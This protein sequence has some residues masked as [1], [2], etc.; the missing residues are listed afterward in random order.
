MAITLGDINVTLQE[1][2][3]TLKEQAQTT[4]SLNSNISVLVK[5]MQSSKLDDREKEIERSNKEK[6]DKAEGKGRAA[7]GGTGSGLFAGLKKGLFAGLLGA[8]GLL[9][10]DNFDTIVNIF[11]NLGKLLQDIINSEAVQWAMTKLKEID[12]AGAFTSIFTT[13][14]DLATSFFEGVKK[15]TEGDY[16][17]AI[18]ENWDG[19]GAAVLALLAF[20]S[21]ARKVVG[22]AIKGAIAAGK[23]ALGAFTKGKD[24]PTERQNKY[25]KEAKKAGV[26]AKPKPGTSSAPKIGA[27][28]TG[29]AAGSLK[30]PQMTGGT[31]PKVDIAKQAASKFPRFGALSKVATKIPVIGTLLS[32][33]A[34]AAILAGDGSK[35]EKVSGVAGLLGGIGGAALGGLV[36]SL[37]LPGI[38]TIAG[39]LIGGLAG[40]TL[41]TAFAQWLTGQKVDAFPFDWA[42]NL[43]N[44]RKEAE[45]GIQPGNGGIQGA[46]PEALPSPNEKVMPLSTRSAQPQMSKPRPVTAPTVANLASQNAANA[47]K[48]IVVIQGG[49]SQT[50][51]NVASTNQGL[52]M[53]SP[54]PFDRA[55]PY[56]SMR[57][58]Y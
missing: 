40:D 12:W 29:P 44:G 31:G 10:M 49:S 3:A 8:A 37:L 18:T 30:P 58:A 25:I 14:K 5:E 32:A 55:D 13:V 47:N 45:A 7:G 4:K 43:A 27:N 16:I 48:Q 56:F 2:N 54:S 51:N 50:V 9:I 39:A 52:V 22:L 46:D 11:K 41:A 20:S 33:G 21:T 28:V 38:G 34:L 24:I 26:V 17:G 36:G 53:P 1:Q 15:I 57:G 6:A 35:E 23:L 42:N 19:I